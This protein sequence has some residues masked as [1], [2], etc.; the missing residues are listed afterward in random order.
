MSLGTLTVGWVLVAMLFLATARASRGPLN[1]PAVL[2]ILAESMALTLL[3]G[4]WFGTAGHGGW[5]LVFLLVGGLAGGAER[6]LRSAFLRSAERF[7]WRGFVLDLARY[8]A[9]G[10]VLAW[11]LA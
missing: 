9:A 5:P 6:G 1:R 2:V 7:D 11:R 8:V 3:A 10:A 4:L